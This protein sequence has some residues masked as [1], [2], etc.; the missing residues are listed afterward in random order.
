MSAQV[1]CGYARAVNINCH[2]SISLI[3]YDTKIEIL[4]GCALNSK[5]KK[6]NKLNNESKLVLYIETIS[7]KKN[8]KKKK[9]TQYNAITLLNQ[10]AFLV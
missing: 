9:I 2:F 8:K 4:F 5:I 7:T 1:F 3:Q 10:T 6:N